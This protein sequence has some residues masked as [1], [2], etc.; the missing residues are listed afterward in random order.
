[1]LTVLSPSQLCAAAQSDSKLHDKLQF[2]HSGGA[3]AKNFAYLVRAWLSPRVCSAPAADQSS[4]PQATSNTYECAGIKD[5]DEF[6]RLKAALA[7]F[8]IKE[9]ARLAYHQTTVTP[10]SLYFV[11]KDL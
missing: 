3:A 6:D 10:A 9:E 1:M 7:A 4:P 11:F 5:A 2:K 8:D